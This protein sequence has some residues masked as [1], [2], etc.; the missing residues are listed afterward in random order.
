[1]FCLEFAAIQS[2][3]VLNNFRTGL[4]EDLEELTRGML[5]VM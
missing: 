5:V 3:N 2:I 4:S 1:M